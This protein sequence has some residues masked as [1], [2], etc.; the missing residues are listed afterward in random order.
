MNA[1][2]LAGTRPPEIIEEVW[3]ALR[4][5]AIAEIVQGVQ[6]LLPDAPAAPALVEAVLSIA[7]H[8]ASAIIPPIAEVVAPAAVEPVAGHVA[9]AIL[10]KVPEVPAVD[11]VPVIARKPP[12][13]H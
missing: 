6:E 7:E 1:D 9:A 8:A 11:L 13:L 10:A 4:A 5:P 12:L 3:Q 2:G